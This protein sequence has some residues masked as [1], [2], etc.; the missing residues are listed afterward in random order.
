[1]ECK[2]EYNDTKLFIKSTKDNIDCS[3]NIYDC[4][5]SGT[6]GNV[7]LLESLNK[8]N[9]VI[10]VSK[11]SCK[12]DLM[13]ELGIFKYLKNNEINNKNFPIYYGDIKR[14]NKFGIIYP[15]LGKYNL[16]KFKIYYINKLS[17]NNN[18][19]II[20]QIIEQLIS[21]ENIIHCDLKSS[22][23]IIDFIENKLIATLTDLGLSDYYYYHSYHFI[24]L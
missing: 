6:I 3:Y 7:Y 16:D 19:D 9:Y 11:D 23:I 10:K 2:I 14:T 1:M 12:K 8:K 4:L 5:G 13:D 15:F 17:F 20:K 21:F 18:I 22:N 24:T